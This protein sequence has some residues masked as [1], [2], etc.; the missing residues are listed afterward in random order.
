MFKML[1]CI[2]GGSAVGGVLRFLVSRWIQS[3]VDVALPWGTLVV[4]VAGCFIIGLVYGLCDRH[5]CI[6]PEMKAFLTVGFCGG[7]T[8]FSTFANENYLLLVTSNIA[9]CIYAGLSFAV[10]L[11]FVH[12]GYAFARVF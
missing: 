1:V 3:A 6:S 10:G 2:G 5:F 11:L 4:N 8:T 7:F 9:V 12:L